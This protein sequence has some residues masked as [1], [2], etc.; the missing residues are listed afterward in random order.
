MIWSIKKHCKKNY[1][2]VLHDMLSQVPTLSIDFD[3][4][5]QTLGQGQKN[6]LLHAPLM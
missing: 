5:P 1:N 6:V 3:P 2:Q 4:S